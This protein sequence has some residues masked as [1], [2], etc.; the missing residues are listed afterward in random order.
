MCWGPCTQ[1]IIHF[2]MSHS[3]PQGCRKHWQQFRLAGICSLLFFYYYFSLGQS[4]LLK[5]TFLKGYYYFRLCIIFVSGWLRWVGFFCLFFLP[6]VPVEEWATSSEIQNDAESGPGWDGPVMDSVRLG[7]HAQRL[8]VDWLHLGR[9]GGGRGAS[10]MQ[11]RSASE[12][13]GEEAAAEGHGQVP[14]G[15]RHQREDPGGGV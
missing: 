5:P 4:V 14:L 3:G 10:E 8:Q 7:D 11:S 1:T 13:R 12:P 9:T 2:G 15:P 6:Q